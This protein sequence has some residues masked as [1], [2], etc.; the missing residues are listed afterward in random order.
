MEKL[1]MNKLDD[2]ELDMVA[3]GGFFDTLKETVKKVAK[4]A[5]D[6]TEKLIKIQIDAMGYEKVKRFFEKLY[7]IVP[8]EK[9]L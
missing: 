8:K 5:V 9:W 6:N 1:M 7:N 2:M 4:P 3:G